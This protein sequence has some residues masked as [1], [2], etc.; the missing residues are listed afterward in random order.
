MM[1]I[2]QLYFKDTYLNKNIDYITNRIIIEYD[3]KSANVS[4]CREYKLLPD[5]EIGIISDMKKDDRVKTIGKRMRKDKVFKE[6]LKKAFVDIRRR[7]FEAN[8]IQDNQILSIKK[9]AIFCIGEVPITKFGCCK[10]VEKNRYTSY[11]YI[12]NPDRLELYYKPSK[13][14]YECEGNIDVKGIDNDILI[15]HDSF[16]N[17]FFISL[18]KKMETEDIDNQ[19]TF[20][21]RFIDR[22]KSLQLEVGYYREYNKT[23]I[24]RLIHEEET[25]DDE[26]FIPYEH[27]QEYID[28]DYNFFNILLP[29]VRMML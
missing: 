9:D 12:N 1:E 23:S 6:G 20:L 10:F 15:K 7:F 13:N 11:M 21:K 24:I 2:S 14:P 17:H 28:I 3:L 29:I 27:K 26:I 25:Y 18:F 22:Y 19:Y 4:L 8:K 16:M 5:D